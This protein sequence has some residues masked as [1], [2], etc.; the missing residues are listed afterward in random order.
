MVYSFSGY[1]FY[2]S[3]QSGDFQA[4]YMQNRKP[5]VHAW[6]YTKSF[7]ELQIPGPHPRTTMESQGGDPRICTFSK[8]PKIVL[9][10]SQNWEL[11]S[12]QGEDFEDFKI[13]TNNSNGIQKVLWEGYSLT[14]TERRELFC[15]GEKN[16]FKGCVT[17]PTDLDERR[18]TRQ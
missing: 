17:F 16:I 12:N 5:E 11:L 3:G 13:K 6:V 4:R 10:L 1:I 7:L 8:F 15:L 14:S 2:L 9:T 18:I